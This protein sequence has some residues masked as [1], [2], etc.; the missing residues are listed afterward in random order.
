MTVWRSITSHNRNYRAVHAATIVAYL[1][2]IDSHCTAEETQRATDSI[3]TQGD[4]R[5]RAK[6]IFDTLIS[7]RIVIDR[8]VL[9]NFHVR[10]YYIDYYSI[11]KHV[12]SAEWL[13]R[14]SSEI[15]TNQILKYYNP[16]SAT[17]FLQRIHAISVLQFTVSQSPPPAPA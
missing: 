4:S 2:R 9:M 11:E 16:N 10:D 5:D 8:K 3:G 17:T 13:G 12:Y 14:A 7:H 15:S 1:F 6:L